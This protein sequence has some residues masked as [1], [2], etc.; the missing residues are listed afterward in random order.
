MCVFIMFILDIYSYTFMYSKKCIYMMYI[1]LYILYA[2]CILYLYVHSYPSP[3]RSPYR[4][5]HRGYFV[6]F[7]G[8]GSVYILYYTPSYNRVDFI[9]DTADVRIYFLCTGNVILLD[10]S[11]FY[12]KVY[13]NNI[14]IYNIRGYI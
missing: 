2:L 12:R 5:A 3:P 11:R 13:Y 8:A 6:E 14:Q 10:E 7:F 9:H 4:R 1:T